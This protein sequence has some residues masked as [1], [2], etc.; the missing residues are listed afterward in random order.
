MHFANPSA[1]FLLIVIA[2]LIAVRESQGSRYRASLAFPDLQVLKG[3]PGTWRTRYGRWVWPLIYA[4]L[5]LGVVA[6]ARPQIVLRG[7]A[8]KARGIDIMVTL[9]TSGSMRA[10]D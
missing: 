10:L 8:A 6:L 2:I 9:D 1:F 7:E 5:I 3:L 4:G